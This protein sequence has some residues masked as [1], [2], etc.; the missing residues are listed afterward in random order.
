MS[1]TK[2]ANNK[3]KPAAPTVMSEEERINL[4]AN[5]ILEIVIE[6]QAKS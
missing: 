3:K 6:E 5:I 4:V 2:G 1:R